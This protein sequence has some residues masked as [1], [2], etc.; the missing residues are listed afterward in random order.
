MSENWR[1]TLIK[2]DIHNFKQ[3]ISNFLNFLERSKIT[4]I[5]DI[6]S[7]IETINNFIT[8]LE[9]FEKEIN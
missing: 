4:D 3:N 1:L 9:N 2:T 8:F 5:K 7:K 6:S